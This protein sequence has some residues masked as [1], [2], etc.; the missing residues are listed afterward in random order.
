MKSKRILSALGQ[1]DERFV[2]EAAVIKPTF[3][4]RRWVRWSALAACFCLVVGGTIWFVNR[5]AIRSSVSDNNVVF[6]EDN[7]TIPPDETT[8][9]IPDYNVTFS[10]D[11]V[12]IPPGEV[13]LSLPDNVEA[14]WAYSFFIYQGRLY[15]SYDHVYG[16]SNLIGEHLGYAKGMIDVWTPKEGYVELAGN[17][18]GDFFSVNGYDPEFM[19]CR[20]MNDGSVQIFINDNDMT[21]K[22]GSDLLEDRFHLSNNLTEVVY[23][24]QYSWNYGLDQKFSLNDAQTLLDLTTMLDQGTFVP[25]S[26]IPLPEGLDY[27][28][29]SKLYHLFLHMK[30][31]TTIELSLLEGGYISFGIYFNQ[32]CIK[33]DAQ[34]FQN[35]ITL[36][37]HGTDS[38]PAELKQGI[39]RTMDECRDDPYFGTYIPTYIPEN[40]SF[41]RATIRYEIEPQ[42]GNILRTE[43]VSLA[44]HCEDDSVQYDIS[45]ADVDD[46]GDIG[47]AG[48]LL[49][50]DDLTLESVREFVS[51]TWKSGKP[52]EQSDTTF[53]VQFGDVMVILSAY[54]LEPT[55]SY[56]I[57]ASVP[58]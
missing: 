56:Q 52:K 25:E 7:V 19:L 23:E 27:L 20:R 35:L 24:N 14:C 9:S 46:Y 26:S 8:P 43:E 15:K 32:V 10:E 5:D 53:G 39:Y 41:E 45:I 57:M 36:F 58:K 34:A 29:Q 51:D 3:A 44:Y 16:E 50:P 18:K 1:V 48:P 6:P 33:V 42:T 49:A 22:Y 38:V 2:D 40:M 31:G 17:F 54:G 12:T 37:E 55:K 13:T 47:W 21:L 28:S 30:N 11:G 4:R